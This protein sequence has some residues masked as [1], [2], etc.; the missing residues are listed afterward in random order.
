MG[1]LHNHNRVHR[2]A[3][4]PAY[5]CD[6]PRTHRRVAPLGKKSETIVDERLIEHGSV[7]LLWP[8][9]DKAQRLRI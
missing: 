1:S 7:A 9:T 6:V 2:H 5:E 8:V 4:N 3:A